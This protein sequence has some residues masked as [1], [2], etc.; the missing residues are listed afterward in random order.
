MSNL[1]I[2]PYWDDFDAEKNYQR[3]LAV[4]GRVEQAREFTQIQTMLQHQITQLGSLQYRDGQVMAGCLLTVNNAKTHATV[5]AGRVYVEGTVID[6]TEAV[7]LDISGSGKEILGLVKTEDIVT[8]VED[9]SLKD[10]AQGYDNY[11]QA[12]AHRLRVTWSWS[13]ISDEGY[14]VFTLKD[15]EVDVLGDDDPKPKP[16][17]EDVLDIIAR[18]DFEKSGNYVLNGLTVNLVQH[19]INKWDM[20]QLIVSAG[21]ARIFGYNLVM[22]ADYKTDLPVARETKE[23]LNEPWTFQPYD[24]VTET[25]GQ[26]TLGERPVATVEVVVATVLAVDGYGSRS[27]V[28]RGQIPG[29]SDELSEDSVVEIVAV[30]QGGTWDPQH[31]T[32]TGGNTFAGT[33]YTRDGNAVDW[34]PAGDEPATGSSYAVAYK[35]RKQ[36][37]KQIMSSQRSVNEDLVHGDDTSDDLITHL[38]PCETNDMTE[39]D[40]FVNDPVGGNPP[41]PDVDGFATQYTRDVDFVVTNSGKLDWYDYDVQILEIIKGSA[42]GTD[43]LTGFTDGYTMGTILDVAKYTNPADMSFDANTNKFVDTDPSSMTEYL[44]TTSYTTS[45]GVAQINWSPGGAEPTTGNH[46]FVAVRARKYKTTVHPQAGHTYYVTYR[47]WDVE[48]AGDYLARDSFYKTWLGVGNVG[49]VL[50]HYGLDLQEIVNFWRSDNYQGAVYNMDKPYPGTMVEVDYL[51]Y[52]PRYVLIDFDAENA[53]NLTYGRSSRRPTEPATDMP[54]KEILLASIYCPADSLDMMLRLKDVK[55]LKVLDLHN[56]RNRLIR[57]EQN[58]ANT[59][60]DMDAKSIPVTNKTGITTTAFHDNDRIDFGW[61]GTQ[62]SIDP[63]WEELALPHVDS[64]YTAELDQNSSTCA[65]Y[66]TFCTLVPNGTEV[67]EQ[68]FYTGNESIAPYALANQDS[69]QSGQ[70]AYMLIQPHGDTVIIPRT[71]TFAAQADADSWAASDIA[72]LTNP[73]RWFSKGWSGGSEKRNVTVGSYGWATFYDTI[74]A[75]STNQTQKWTTE[76]MRDIQGN[77]RQ[78]QVN[79]NIPGGLIP[80]ANAALD[81]Y[82]YFGGI[83][84]IPTLTNSTPPGAVSG[85]FRPRPLDNGASGYFTIPANVPEGRIEIKATSTPMTINGQD[86]RQTLIAIYDAAVVEKLTMEFEK[87]RCNCWCYCNCNCW[88]CR[89]RC[90]TGPLAETLEPIGRQRMLKEIAVDFY[91][92]HPDYGVFGCIVRTDNGNPTSNTVSDGMIARGFR[93][94]AQMAGAGMK[95]FTFDDPVYFKDEAYAIVVTG[96][97]GFNLNSIAE[98]AAGRDIRCKIATLGK[99]DVTTGKVVGSQPFKSGILWR[100]LTGVTWEQDQLSDLK[101]TAT[102]HTYSTTAEH[103]AYMQQVAVTNATAF[104]LNWDSTAPQG[105][106]VTFEY[107]TQDGDWTEFSPYTITYLSQV[108]STLYFRARMK[109]AQA[110]ISPFVAQ[111]AGLYVQSTQTSMKAVTRNFEVSSSDIAEI[112]LDT[113]LPSGASQTVRITFDNGVSWTTLNN[114]SNGHPTGNLI[115]YSAVDLNDE[116][117]KYRHHWKVQLTPPNVFTRV[118]VEITCSVIG[119]GARL[120]DPRFSRL[121]VI[122]SSS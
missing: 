92:V 99:Q 60:L 84:V 86:W 75:P 68:P 119:T 3:I 27:L 8:E 58:L 10:P 39:W 95:T 19:P 7:T 81:F 56:V 104:V 41:D 44:V 55:T 71:L 16:V 115:E 78:I 38:W 31:E 79:F 47:Y 22:S 96:E 118:R 20:K 77:C 57:T 61:P 113:H 80:T 21:T 42:N 64:F 100:S 25:G 2:N 101:F 62:Y 90:G 28:T 50:Q 85:T 106:M 69:L 111:F 82:L 114:S 103:V 6:F 74:D 109:T 73:T 11:N 52:L 32:F 34:S 36:M 4:P 23:S 97:D 65:F 107:R 53:I 110:S 1:N 63:D 72:K 29:G 45:V 98:I 12:G 93:S 40:F 117:V 51:Y 43:N 13:V 91:S 112:W 94:A 33:A 120:L 121:I 46:Y 18:R 102:F 35:Y 15:G 122:S 67:I 17:K 37:V 105:T 59:W 30:N 24:S 70:S 88:N 54:E 9:P 49:N 83:R 87:C 5:S 48:V 108:A 26:F 89:G 76:Y 116:N 14:G 66:N